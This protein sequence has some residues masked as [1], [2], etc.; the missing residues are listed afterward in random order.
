MEGDLNNMS[1][2]NALNIVNALKNAHMFYRLDVRCDHTIA[3]ALLLCSTDGCDKII[4]GWKD[5]VISTMS[6]SL[7]G[8]E[9]YNAFRN[10]CSN[11]PNDVPMKLKYM[12]V[13]FKHVP[14]T[15]AKQNLASIL[16][17]FGSGVYQMAPVPYVAA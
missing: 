10:W 9:K 8:P 11:S 15:L 3:D 12:V 4:I 7:C 5:D 2:T 1:W 6:E 16:I 13:H 14:S 17:V